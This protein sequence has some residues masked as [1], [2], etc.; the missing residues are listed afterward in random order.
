MDETDVGSLVEAE[1]AASRR[2]AEKVGVELILERRSTDTTASVDSRR[3]RRIL[4]NLITN[5]IEHAEQKPVEVVVASNDQAVAVTVRD[6]GVGFEAEDAAR[7]FDRF[8]RAD[9]SRTRIVGGSGLGLAISMEDAR[10]HRGWLT[11]W[12]RP[13]RG[14][15]F[16]LTLPREPGHELTI[17]P[18]SVIPVDDKPKELHR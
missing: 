5:A 3:I 10:L 12:G 8:W 11:A 13:N 17:S 18:L 4:R 1:L 6:H 2:M 14:A 15:Q 16:R 7:V 9:P